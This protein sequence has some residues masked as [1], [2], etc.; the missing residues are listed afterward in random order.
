MTRGSRVIAVLAWLLVELYFLNFLDAAGF[1]CLVAGFLPSDFW[2][3]GCFLT[4]LKLLVPALSPGPYYVP[5]PLVSA[6]WPQ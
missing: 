3:L 4:L 6:H 2:T 1:D 5:W